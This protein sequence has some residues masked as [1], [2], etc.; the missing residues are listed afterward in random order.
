MGD[1]NMA[2]TIRLRGE[3]LIN[4]YRYAHERDYRLMFGPAQ[5]YSAEFAQRHDDILQRITDHP[6]Q[7]VKVVT[8]CDDMCLKT[9][10]PK[11]SE[12]CEAADLLAKDRHTAQTFGVELGVAYSADGL[13]RQLDRLPPEKAPK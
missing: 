12:E 2:E 4:L 8:G 9:P 6:E 13:L 1:A 7:P 11:R 10:C 3:H 5:G